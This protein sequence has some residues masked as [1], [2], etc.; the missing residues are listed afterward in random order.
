MNEVKEFFFFDGKNG[1]EI[2]FNV[3]VKNVI[4][5]V[6]ASTNPFV[7]EKDISISNWRF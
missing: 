3:I 6:K 4:V 5:P 2:Y 7:S 1:Q